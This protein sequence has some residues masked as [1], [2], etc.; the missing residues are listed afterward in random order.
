[1]RVKEISF[2][3]SAKI[4]I[5]HVTWQVLD[6]RNEGEHSGRGAKEGGEDTGAEAEGAGGGHQEEAGAA[7]EDAEIH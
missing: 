2:T 7:R 4:L 5:Y 6:G 3:S 1:M